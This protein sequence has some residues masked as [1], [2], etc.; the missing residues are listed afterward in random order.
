MNASTRQLSN[1]R[2]KLV[3]IE[4]PD[5]AGKTTAITWL[6]QHLAAAN[7]LLLARVVVSAQPPQSLRQSVKQV[8][9][10]DSC[11]PEEAALIFAGLQTLS[12]FN[13]VLPLS[14]NNFVVTDRWSLSTLCYQAGF[15]ADPEFL[16]Q[17]VAHVP[18]PDLTIVINPGYEECKRRITHC[19]VSG[20]V[21]DKDDD[22]QRFVH[23]AYAMACA[24]DKA[25]GPIVSVSTAEQVIEEFVKYAESMA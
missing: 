8:V 14:P 9:M 22:L 21:F 10:A 19:R 25:Y 11:F 6:Q 3:A 20:S 13:E 7:P 15:G 24:G 1:T 23:R 4:G 18:T 12:W 17:V 5:G 16:K 2:A